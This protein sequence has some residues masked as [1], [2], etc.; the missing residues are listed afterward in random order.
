MVGRPGKIAGSLAFLPGAILVQHR[1]GTG[2]FLLDASVLSQGVQA[3]QKNI[4]ASHDLVHIHRGLLLFLGSGQHVEGDVSGCGF[5]CD[6]GRNVTR[7]SRLLCSLGSDIPD[8]S[9]FC[10][11]GRNVTRCSRFCGLGRHIP[12][13]S[14]FWCLGGRVPDSVWFCIPLDHD[15][16][17]LL[18]QPPFHDLCLVTVYMIFMVNILIDQISLGIHLNNSWP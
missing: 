15:F 12:A 2:G 1:G 5:F 18:L 17:L 11:L 10:S 4:L 3:D 7:C 9:M 8:V 13:G 16:M 6:L 14:I